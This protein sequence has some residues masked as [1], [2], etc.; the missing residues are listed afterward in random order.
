MY[1]VSASM[2]ESACYCGVAPF[3]YLSG[4][5]VE[6]KTK[7]YFMANKKLKC[8]L[9]MASLT[10]VKLDYDLKLCYEIKAA[11]G[12]NKMSVSNAARNKL[13]GRPCLCE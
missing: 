6:E 7:L 13:L 12:K 5:S 10:A 11:K 2:W 3:E 9:H 1:S 4:S 8:K